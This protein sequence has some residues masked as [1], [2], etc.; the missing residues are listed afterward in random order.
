M[1]DVM[2]PGAATLA[3]LEAIWR[4][5]RAVTLERSVRPAVEAA[6]DLVRRASEG[7]EAV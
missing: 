2:T 6:A 5:E 3:Q 7:E 4:G 1:S